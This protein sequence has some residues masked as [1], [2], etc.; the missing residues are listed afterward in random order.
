M[1]QSTLVHRL[2]H[3]A[4]TLGSQA[5]LRFRLDNSW[6]D[7]SWEQY[8]MR[9]LDLAAGLVELGVSAQDRVAMISHNQPN[10]VIGDLAILAAGAASVPA[11]PNSIP[12][13]VEYLLQHSEA[14]VIFVADGAQLR[15]VQQVRGACPALRHAILM[16]DDEL[17]ADGEFV[18]TLSSVEARGIKAGREQVEARIQGLDPGSLATIIYTSGTTGPPKGVMLSHRNLTFMADAI[19]QVVE[20]EEGDSTLSFLPLSHVAERLQGQVCAVSEGLTV[21]YGES[22]ETIV[23]DLGEV[24]ATTLLCVPRLWEK[25]YASIHSGLE[26]ASPL[27]KRLFDWAITQGTE[28]FELRNSG[29]EPGPILE[30]KLAVADRLIFSKVRAKLGMTHTRKFLSGA[31]PLSAQVGT[32]FASLG[33]VIQEAYGQTECTGVSNVNPRA[34]V[35]FGTVGPQLPGV[36][37]RIAEDGEILVRGPHVFLGYFHDDAATAAALDGE[38]LATGDVGE[39]DEDGH[40]RITDRKKDILVTAGGKNV[41]PQNI[42]NLL[43]PARGIS[44][45]VVVGDKRKFLSALITL[46]YPEMALVLDEVLPEGEGCVDHP[47]VLAHVQ[48]CIDEVNA[49]LPSYETIKQFRVLPRDLTIEDGEITPTLKVKR[50]VVQRSY[51]SLIDSMYSEKFN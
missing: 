14:Q 47:R 50:R 43:K 22:M 11:Y 18:L 33:L 17:L 7:I 4:E 46:D 26:D 40:L 34:H 24:N 42:E 35:K 49:T 51:E 9:V 38:W 6:R 39:I 31:A 29:S 12:S 37:V 41:A 23:R 5:A 10:W 44:Q 15:K 20:F 21:N 32:F 13:Q 19:S 36:E 48:G 2:E 16:D 45:V 27:K 30:A 25:I 8:R 3:Q 1:N 28:A